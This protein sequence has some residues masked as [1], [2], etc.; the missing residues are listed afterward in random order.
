MSSWSNLSVK[1][2]LDQDLDKLKLKN[3]S[4][5]LGNYF[6]EIVLLDSIVYMGM[7]YSSSAGI[8]SFDI[9]NELKFKN[10][11]ITN[12]NM[13]LNGFHFFVPDITLDR[14]NNLWAISKNNKMKPI[15]VIKDDQTRYIS[16]EES[17]YLLSN[18]SNTL[19][20]DNFNRLWIGSPDD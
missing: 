13:S 12:K 18:D 20:V 15:T 1:N 9:S 6:S 19:T 16:I 4:L 17:N 5:D 8:A 3:I 11:L 10:S 7:Y 2:Y 14:K